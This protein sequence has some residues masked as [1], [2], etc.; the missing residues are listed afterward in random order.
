MNASKKLDIYIDESGDFSSF[1]F[2]NPL[3][4]ISFVLVNNNDDNFVPINKFENN[5]NNL[6][7]GNHF[8]HIGNLVRC[9]KPYEKMSRE[10]RWKL[11]YALHLFAFY[12][13]YMVVT[14]TIIKHESVE[15]TT[16]AIA[17]S[18]LNAIDES[19]SYL[20][21]FDEITLHYD[22]GQNA[23]AGIIATGFLSRFPNC[24][25]VKTPQSQNSFMQLADL[26]A[27]FE[28][29]KYKISK[30]YLSNSESKFFG[31]IK[32]L[33][34]KYIKKLESKYLMNDVKK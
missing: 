22:Y 7:G 12:A 8:V 9:E 33:K 25:I 11:F 5:L 2:E 29:L 30:S 13:K 34:D 4:S 24:K 18:L 20:N 27:Y 16:A 26:F 6:I 14:S 3:Y 21:R 28:L 15:E 23:L 31:G 17:K 19:S 32:E 10:E 1:S